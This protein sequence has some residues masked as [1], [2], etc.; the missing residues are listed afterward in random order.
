M[1]M[2]VLTV[3]SST[4]IFAEQAHSAFADT[5]SDPELVHV[6]RSAHT[7]GLKV[8]L[9]IH[10]ALLNDP[11]HSSADVG[12]HFTENKWNEWFDSYKKMLLHYSTIAQL[13]RVEQLCVGNELVH[14]CTVHSQ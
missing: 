2:N 12:I 7:L 4:Q 10:L 14:A 6:I 5:A 1:R 11:Q 9:K 3:H 8:M 13:E